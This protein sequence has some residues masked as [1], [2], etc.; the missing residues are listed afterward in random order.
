MWLARGVEDGRTGA[1]LYRVATRLGY[2]ALRARTRRTAYEIA[3]G[4]ETA[5][6]RQ[7][8][9]PAAEVERR[10]RGER[11]RAALARLD[12]RQAQILSLRMAGLTYREMAEIL[13]VKPGSVGTLLARAEAEFERAYRALDGELHENQSATGGGHA[14]AR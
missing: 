5:L 14:S 11:V 4:S 7:A 6:N 8:D 13:Q 2:N 1:W 10:I 3:A 9:D 12:P